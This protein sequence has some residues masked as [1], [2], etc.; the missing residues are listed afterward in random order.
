MKKLFGVASDENLKFEKYFCVYLRYPAKYKYSGN[1]DT[2][3]GND[4]KVYLDYSFSLD[5]IT[6]PLFNC[7][8]LET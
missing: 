4:L 5:L 6:S 3:Y 2:L 7:S 1:N 8:I